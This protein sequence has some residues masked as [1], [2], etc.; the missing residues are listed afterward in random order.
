MA[1]SF[2]CSN[3]EHIGIVYTMPVTFVKVF[4]QIVII[5][6]SRILTIIPRTLYNTGH[7]NMTIIGD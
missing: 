4:K 2:R 5:E 1:F 6:K 7:N 3:V